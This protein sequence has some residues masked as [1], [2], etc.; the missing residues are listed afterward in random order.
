MLDVFYVI[1]YYAFGF[2]LPIEWNNWIEESA[3]NGMSKLCLM[4]SS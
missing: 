3:L 4:L 2:S 1:K